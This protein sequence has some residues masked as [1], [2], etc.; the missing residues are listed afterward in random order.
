M[1]L[2]NKATNQSDDIKYT[3]RL[4]ASELLRALQ[5]II[6]FFIMDCRTRWTA[7]ADKSD[8]KSHGERKKVEKRD[9]EPL[10]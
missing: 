4:P 9:T 5:Q 7:I 3:D 1:L 8:I 6:L 10:N 2:P